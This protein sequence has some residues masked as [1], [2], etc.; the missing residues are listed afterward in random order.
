MI[1]TALLVAV[2]ISVIIPPAVRQDIVADQPGEVC[3]ADN[4]I[5]PSE[6]LS[7][8]RGDC[9]YFTTKKQGVGTTLVLVSPI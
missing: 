1:H 2:K 6:L 3:G 8:K 9:F 4:L 5:V 7:T